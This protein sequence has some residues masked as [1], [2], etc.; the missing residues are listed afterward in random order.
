MHFATFACLVLGSFAVAQT[1][2]NTC[3][4]YQE[5]CSRSYANVTHL[6]T[7]NG[8]AVGASIAANQHNNIT[9]QLDDGVRG[10]MLDLRHKDPSKPTFTPRLCHSECGFLDAG[11]L[12]DT[13]VIIRTWLEK[14]KNN[15]ITIL[16]E[17]AGKFTTS[18]IAAQF[19]QAGLDQYAYKFGNGQ[20]PTLQAM[21][22]S[23]QNV[24]VFIDDFVPDS[25]GTTVPYLAAEYAYVWETPYQIEYKNP[26]FTCDVDRPK[27]GVPKVPTPLYVLNHFVYGELPITGASGVSTSYP[28]GANVTNTNSLTTHVNQCASDKGKPNFVAVDFYEVG[29]VQNVVSAMNSVQPPPKKQEAIKKSAAS[30]VHLGPVALMAVVVL[31]Y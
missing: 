24:V 22:A 29:D 21:I 15:V 14:N 8:Y 20:W 17:N 1:T 27:S 25:D 9:Q 3:N 5:L 23:N 13:L 28:Q 4:G 11:T 6:T 16:F 31:F 19:A 2:T 18:A 30:A 10:L 12:A 26:T 7:H